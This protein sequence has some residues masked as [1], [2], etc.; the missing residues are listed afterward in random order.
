MN[1]NINTKSS[2]SR[3]VNIRTYDGREKKRDGE[4]FKKNKNKK[5][6]TR[7]L[8]KRKFVIFFLYTTNSR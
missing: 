3:T 1:K 7:Y 2:Y 5:I 4:P 6:K 8:K